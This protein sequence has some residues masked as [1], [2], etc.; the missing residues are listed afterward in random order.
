MKRREEEDKKAALVAYAEQLGEE[1]KSADRQNA[2]KK[3]KQKRTAKTVMLSVVT[4]LSV[5][6][7]AGLSVA[8]A[9]FSSCASW[10]CATR[11]SAAR[12]GCACGATTAG[13]RSMATLTPMIS[14]TKTM[15]SLTLP[16]SVG[17]G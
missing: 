2:A 8:L 4:A 17:D 7:I 3:N 16:V 1:E 9:Y 14:S 5:G 15:S 6:A 12:M 13:K 11:S 10:L